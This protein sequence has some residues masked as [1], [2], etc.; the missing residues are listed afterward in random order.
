MSTIPRRVLVASAIALGLTVT[1]VAP[2]A[3]ASAPSSPITHAVAAGVDDPGGGPA[4]V[5]SS[6]TEL[7]PPADAPRSGAPDA[8]PTPGS[9]G[10]ETRVELTEGTTMLGLSW[11]PTA[12]VGDASSPLGRIAWRPVAD[13][14]EG[15]WT[16]STPEPDDT[17]EEGDGRVGSELIVLDA[18][19]DAVDLRVEAGPLADLRLLQVQAEPGSEPAGADDVAPAPRAASRAAQPTI[20]LRSAWTTSG[21][22]SWNPGCGSSPPVAGSLRHAVVHHTAGSNT[23]SQGAVPGILQGMYLH[24]TQSL[25]WCD[26]GYQFL[27]DRFGRI[28]QGRSGSISQP[29]V[30]GHARGFNTGSVGIALMGQFEPGASPAYATPASVMLDS[31]ARLLAWKLDLHGLDPHGTVRVTSGGSTRYPSGTSVTLPVVNHHRQTSTT[32]CPGQLVIDRMPAMRNAIASHMGSGPS[33]PPPPDPGDWAPFSDAESLVWR[34]FSDFRRDPGTWTQRRWWVEAL[35]SGQTNRNALV[36]SLIRS[37]FV[38]DRSSAAIRLYQAYFLRVPDHAGI[39]Y[40]WG[41]VDAGYGLRRM[42]ADMAYS[43]EFRNRYGG[44]GDEAFVRLVYRNVMGRE[45]EPAGVDYWTGRLSSRSESRGGLMVLF[46]ESAEYRSRMRD[47]V[48]V[49]LVH[50]VMLGRAISEASLSTWVGRVR[51]D[52]IGALTGQLFASAEYAARVG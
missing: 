22:A 33:D 26:V 37:D 8:G 20:R 13:G 7:S 41:R 19:A 25:R 43:A 47:R 16:A 4:D 10:W 3:A 51:T 6:M 48:E 17:G 18:P 31:A 11:D 9:P 21:W 12:V 14:V 34:Q 24:H 2:V 52:G 42:S 32:L 46:S 39:R 36:A 40:W 5:T 23:Y 29:V 49:A 44:L 1:A 35:S 50:E 15:A 38:D 45:G 28:W 30:G 27:V